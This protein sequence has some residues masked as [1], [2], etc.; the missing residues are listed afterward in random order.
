MHGGLVLDKMFSELGHSSLYATTEMH[1]KQDH[2][3]LI[4]ALEGMK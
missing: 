1:T 4:A 2:D 3:R